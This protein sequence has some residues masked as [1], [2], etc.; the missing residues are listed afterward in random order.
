MI[1][2][3]LNITNFKNIAEAHLDFSPNV[4]GLLGRNGM[5]KSNLLDAVYYLSLCK[6]FSGLTDERLIRNGDT[7]A[8]LRGQYLR[9]GVEEE[10]SLGLAKGRRKQFKRGGKEY[11]RLSAHIGNFPLVLVSPRDMDL[12]NGAPEERRK[13]ID[14]IISQA[15]PVYLDK[16]IRYNG[17]LQQRNRLLRDKVSDADLLASV[18]LPMAAVAQYITEARARMIERFMPMFEKHYRDISRTDEQPA[19]RYSSKMAESSRPLDELLNDSRAKDLIL[20]H[21]TVGPHRDDIELL[22]NDMPVKTTASQGQSKTFTLAMRLSQYEFLHEVV[23]MKP[24]LLLDDIFDKLDADR[25]AHIID[26]VSRDIFGQI[27]ITDTNRDHLDSIMAMTGADYR[28]WEV[29]D[30]HFSPV[31]TNVE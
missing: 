17:L 23:G 13:F 24:I 6:S 29:S 30:G 15:D 7:F 25:V 3:S 26:I 5:G 20:G 18:E 16:L 8:M 22:L 14:M 9:K 1:L 28:L 27:F 12:V 11:Q 21:T 2:E 4:N 19:L 31:K 10:L